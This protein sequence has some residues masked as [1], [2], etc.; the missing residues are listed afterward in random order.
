MDFAYPLGKAY[1]VFMPGGDFNAARSWGKHAA[2]DYPVGPVPC[3]NA[4]HGKVVFAGWAGN[5]GNTV[6]VQG[7]GWK[8]RYIH[9][10]RIDVKVGAD[11]AQGQQLGL[12][13]N[14]TDIAGGVG[15]HLHFAIWAQTEALAKTIQPDPYLTQGW[16][17]IDPELVLGKEDEVPTQAEWEQF[18]KDV[19]ASDK[20]LASDIATLSKKVDDLTNAVIASDASLQAQITASGLK[21]GDTVK[22]T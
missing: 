19:V 15:Y 9:L 12:T 21:R 20:Q 18:Q 10:S 8:C 3:F 16:W 5:A 4:R 17:A 11:L 22:L 2:S 7:D 13:G 6:E 1:P 14:T